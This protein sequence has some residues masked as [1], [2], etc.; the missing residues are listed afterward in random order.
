MPD[1]TP[2]LWV[3]AGRLNA[4]LPRKPR[5]KPVYSIKKLGHDVAVAVV[6]K[7]DDARLIATAPELLEEL[8]YVADGL[9]HI[10][11]PWAKE[12]LGFVQNAITKA[13][14]QV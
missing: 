11:T 8:R 2:G 1:R 5:I 14:G 7:V 10:D 9:Q 3:L 12:R 6:G 4:S 13:E